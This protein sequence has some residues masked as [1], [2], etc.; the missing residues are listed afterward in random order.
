MPS[1]VGDN[2]SPLTHKDIEDMANAISIQADRSIMNTIANHSHT[3]G[4]MGGTTG[5]MGNTFGTT[6]AVYQDDKA[7]QIQVLQERVDKLEKLLN[8]LIAEFM[9]EYEV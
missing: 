7:V 8:V 9:P 3:S 5:N 2:T 6:N 4:S 1:V